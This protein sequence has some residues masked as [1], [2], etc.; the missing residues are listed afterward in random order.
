M[1]ENHDVSP[2]P[3]GRNAQAGRL[4]QSGDACHRLAREPHPGFFKQPRHAA[5]VFEKHQPRAE[6]P[7]W[8][9]RRAVTRALGPRTVLRSVGVFLGGCNFCFFFLFFFFCSIC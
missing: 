1:I 5:G 3:G 2:G 4:T 6:A 9:G 8:G 7:D